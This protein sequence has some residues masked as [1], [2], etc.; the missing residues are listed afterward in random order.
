VVTFDAAE[1]GTSVDDWTAAEPWAHAES[2]DLSAVRHLVVLAAHPDDET[3]GAG[4]LIG[5]AA[6]RGIPVTIIENTDGERSHPASPGLSVNDLAMRRRHEVRAAVDVLAPHATIQ[7]LGLPDGRISPHAA[8]LRSLLDSALR[9]H[10]SDGLLVVFPWVGDGH[11]DHRVVAEV[12]ISLIVAMGLRALAYPIWMWH[13]ATPTEPGLPWYACSVLHL[14]P[15]SR[16]RKGDALHQFQT[17]IVGVSTEPD[18]GPVLHAEMLRHFDRDVE[19]FFAAGV[20]ANGPPMETAM[21]EPVSMTAEYFEA[22]HQRHADPWGFDT[23]WYERRKRALTLASL[24]RR[25]YRSA[26]EVGCSTG[27]LTTELAGRCEQ[28]LAVDI[29]AEAVA[30]AQANLSR[31]PHVTV[32]QATLPREWPD[33]RFDL[34]VLSEVGYYWSRDDLTRAILAVDDSLAADG[35]LVLCH[36]RHPVE[37]YPLSGDEVHRAFEHSSAVTRVA[38]HV[39]DDFVLAVYTRP[40]ALSVA[41]R[42]GLIP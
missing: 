8:R 23:R 32:R 22:F 24:P 34:I 28:L 18:G 33:G 19:V 41:Q 9:D 1:P 17:Q 14:S 21:P 4:G 27:R 20:T 29:A 10:Q 16:S 5:E 39:E 12:A 3:L 31:K 38:H 7:F 37:S 36:W 6:D 35:E 13:W 30:R 11:R 2:V 42:E 40:P 15:R 26:L 25:R